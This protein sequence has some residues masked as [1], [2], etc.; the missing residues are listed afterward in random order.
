MQKFKNKVVLI[1]GG[2]NGMGFT[3]A[4]KFIT[5]GAKVVITGRSEETINRAI[6][7]LG[8][9]AIGIVSNAGKLS[10]IL[11][12]KDQ[13]S[14][15]TDQIDILFVNAGYGKFMPIEMVRESD[16]DELFDLLVKGTFFTVQQI[17]P[18]MPKGSSIILNTTFLTEVGHPNMS[19]YTAAKAAVQSLIKTFAAE[20]TSKEIRVNGI[21]PGY[22]KT[23]IFNNT[24]L[25]PEEIKKTIDAVIPTLP[26][27][28]FGEPSEIAKTVL[29]LAS[30]DASYIHGTEITVDGGLSRTK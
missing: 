14:K 22:I 28:R 2:T 16:F 21:S 1:T 19:V 20:C 15:H 6:K 25:T 24:G 5:E 13:I 9:N 29:F 8:T 27:K 11:E 3:T 18:L 4:Q 17:L 23:N 10:D 26:F 12:L 30:D 7:E